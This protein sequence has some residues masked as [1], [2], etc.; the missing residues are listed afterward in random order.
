MFCCCVYLSRFAVLNKDCTHL[1]IVH[2]AFLLQPP[3]MKRRVKLEEVCLALA[4]GIG[5]DCHDPLWPSVN[6]PKTKL[7]IVPLSGQSWPTWHV[8]AEC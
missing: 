7:A 6:V 2:V 4:N 3:K 8:Q 1:V 5:F